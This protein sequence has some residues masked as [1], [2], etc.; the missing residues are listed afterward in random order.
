MTTLKGKLTFISFWHPIKLKIEN[1]EVD[2]R[3]HY[4]DV[5]I[6]LNGKKASM[7]GGMNDLTI[8]AD[9]NSKNVMKF[10]KN[11][12]K[13]TILMILDVIDE[14]GFSNLGAYVPD[15]LERLNGMQVIVDVNKNSIGIRHN[16]TEK[17]H[18]M[19]YTYN[20]SC[21]VSDEEVKEICKVGQ[22][23]C[24]IFLTAG[25]N[26][27]SCCKFD[28]VMSRILLDRHAEGSMRATR[29]GNCKIIGR[30]EI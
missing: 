23:D 26:G 10:E 17:V 25:S 18:E 19:K 21:K 16:E 15:M 30:I 3:D 6:N 13:D 7:K 24:C 22:E 14:F 20:N 11:D 29:I 9:E 2:L 28:G 27:F 1:G 8:F 4:F 5:F 12:E